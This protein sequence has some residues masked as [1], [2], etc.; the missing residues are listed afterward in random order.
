MREARGE[1]RRSATGG[2]GRRAVSAA[3]GLAGRHALVAAAREPEGRALA[4]ALAA[5]GATVSVAT[6][7]DDRAE[8]VTAHSI[9][10]E[11]WTL[12]RDG[13]A[14]RLDLA[15]PAAA[16]D[17]L[18][19]LE[20]AVA[21]L[22]ALVIA[23]PREGDGDASAFAEA[24]ARRMAER[25]VGRIAL[26]A[27]ADGGEAAR[28]LAASLAARWAERGVGVSAVEAGGDAAVAAAGGAP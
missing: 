5:A 28:A 20:A 22:D 27:G 19:G 21:P 2:G 26:C 17:A 25:G 9:L 1:R 6:A 23:P 12:G 8:E 13:R 10:N 11:C 18:D 24:A 16:E 4:L 3:D 7:R 14:L 15:D